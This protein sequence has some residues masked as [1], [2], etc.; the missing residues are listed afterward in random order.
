MLLIMICPAASLFV[1]GVARGAE[2]SIWRSLG[3]A[4]LGAAV[5][6][7]TAFAMLA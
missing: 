3:I 6:A 5:F 1:Y 2:W 4:Q 7:V